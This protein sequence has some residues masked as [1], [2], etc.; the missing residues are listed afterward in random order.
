MESS[1]PV[2]VN[3]HKDSSELSCE[4]RGTVVSRPLDDIMAARAPAKTSNDKK[5]RGRRG[6]GEAAAKKLDVKKQ[7]DR[8][9]GGKAAKKPNDKKKN[10][11]A[12]ATS[13]GN[14]TAMKVKSK[15]VR[16]EELARNLAEYVTKAHIQCHTCTGR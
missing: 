8:R 15:A 2:C 6:G 9:G 13:K 11:K 10:A 5:L 7:P 4:V 12:K 3:L 14:N 16:A 1:G